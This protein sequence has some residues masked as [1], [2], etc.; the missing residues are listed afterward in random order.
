M[1]TDPNEV[2][3]IYAGPLTVV[4]AYL[5]ALA[6]AGIEGKMVGDSLLAS[7]GSAIPDAIELYV[8]QRD[9]EKGLAAI[10]FYEESEKNG[11]PRK[12]HD[13]S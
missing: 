3:K 6:D 2:V 10:K 7:F 13:R 9:V 5:Q 12:H 4:E 11:G 1:S 8:H